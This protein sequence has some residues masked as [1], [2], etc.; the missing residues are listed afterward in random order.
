MKLATYMFLAL[1]FVSV[2]NNELKLVAYGNTIELKDGLH[3]ETRRLLFTAPD[4]VFDETRDTYLVAFYGKGYPQVI[5]RIMGHTAKLML[6]DVDKDGSNELLLFYHAGGNQ[7]QLKVY[8]LEKT[9]Y[10][11]PQIKPIGEGVFSSN[12]GF[13]K[14]IDGEIIVKNQFR[15]SVNEATITTEIYR[16]VNGALISTA[17]TNALIKEPN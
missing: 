6:D 9:E 10:S 1:P 16:L 3:V 13:V 8:V 11:E 5:D 2:A 12:M 4:G 7:Y 17:E 14:V 15:H